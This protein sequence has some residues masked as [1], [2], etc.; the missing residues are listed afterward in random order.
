MENSGRQRSKSSKKPQ[1]LAGIAGDMIERLGEFV[2]RAGAPEWGQK[3]YRAGNRLEHLND[4]K[5]QR[6]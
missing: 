5:S 1:S 3:I 6:K 4:K 2:S